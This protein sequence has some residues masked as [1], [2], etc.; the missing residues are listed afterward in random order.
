[1]MSRHPSGPGFA[2]FPRCTCVSFPDPLC[3]PPSLADW[4]HPHTLHLKPKEQPDVTEGSSPTYCGYRNA[5]FSN[6]EHS[7]SPSQPPGSAQL[8]RAMAGIRVVNRTVMETCFLGCAP[9][10]CPDAGGHSPP[11]PKH[12]ASVLTYI[13]L[14]N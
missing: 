13:L 14:H 8:P 6:P 7:I 9:T 5:F 2:G 12:P 11:G 4:S 3:H 1:M 10:T